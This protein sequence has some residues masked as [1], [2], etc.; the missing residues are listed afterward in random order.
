MIK[1]DQELSLYD[2]KG[3]N[4]IARQQ[5]KDLFQRNGIFYIFNI[6]K[7][8]K[9][10]SIYLKNTFPFEINYA[11]VNL[12]TPQDLKDTKKLILKFKI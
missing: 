7:L 1:K 10:K 8:L 9:F 6:K 2:P 12:D 5:L 4:I 11:Y 3:K